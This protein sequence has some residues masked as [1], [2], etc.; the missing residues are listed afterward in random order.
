MYV[1]KYMRSGKHWGRSQVL[2]AV[3]SYNVT[4]AASWVLTAHTVGMLWWMD[5][6]KFL[7]EDLYGNRE[8]KLLPLWRNSLRIWSSS[9]GWK[10]TGCVTVCWRVCGSGLEQ[11]TWSVT[12]WWWEYVTG[13]WSGWGSVETTLNNLRKFM[14]CWC[15][16]TWETWTSWCVLQVRNSRLQAVRI[17]WKCWK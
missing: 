15:W 8:W 16:F 17:S 2:H 9:V 4:A 10:C 1:Y 14:N 11:M 7:R 12:A 5:A 3:T 13:H 6:W